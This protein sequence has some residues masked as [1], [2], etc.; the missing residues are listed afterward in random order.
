MSAQG[1]FLALPYPQLAPLLWLQ[2]SGEKSIALNTV[3]EV[4]T[5][6]VFLYNSAVPC[7]NEKALSPGKEN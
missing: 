3:V 2:C 1:M 5:E 7:V 6:H 4:F